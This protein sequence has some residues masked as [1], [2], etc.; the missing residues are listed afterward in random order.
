MT[1]PNLVWKDSPQKSPIHEYKYGFSFLF[2][3]SFIAFTF[4]GVS[5][6]GRIHYDRLD[7]LVYI[8]QSCPQ[9]CQLCAVLRLNL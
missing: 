3:R 8:Q 7:D 5:Q 2:N 1:G 4:H 9:S 6:Y